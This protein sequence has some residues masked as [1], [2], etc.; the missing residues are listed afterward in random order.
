MVSVAVEAGTRG[1]LG[2]LAAE[3]LA[4]LRALSVVMGAS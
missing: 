2:D 1:S 3:H 4:V